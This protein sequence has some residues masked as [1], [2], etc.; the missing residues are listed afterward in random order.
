M[1]VTTP[2]ATMSGW[3]DDL[4]FRQLRIGPMANFVYLIGSKR[5]HEA[6]AVDPAWDITGILQV[7]EQDGMR[8]TGA[9]VTHTHPDHVGGS[10]G[11]QEI[12]GLPSLLTRQGVKVHVHK[13]EADALPLAASDL[14][15]TDEHSEL[16]L[17]DLRLRFI[18]TP[19][20]TPG[21]Q[22][23]LL[24]GAPGGAGSSEDEPAGRLVSGD[25]LFI[26][27]CGR[28]DLPG[29]DPGDLYESLTGKLMKLDAATE[30]FPG[31]DY[32][33]GQSHSTIEAE[34]A[35]NPYCNFPSRAAFLQAMGYGG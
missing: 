24:E 32:A 23:F 21:S 19:G 14:V 15:K 20:H 26:G 33:Q 18:H 31:H 27:A 30:V 34:Q 13:A 10:F 35:Q 11:G 8:L 3:Q 4:Y 17:G 5:T 7:L 16:T 6:V 29:S 22:C 28:A 25:T 9:L 2:K 1:T 12:E